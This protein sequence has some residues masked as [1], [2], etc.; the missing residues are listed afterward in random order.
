MWEVRIAAELKISS[1]SAHRSNVPWEICTCWIV[2]TTNYLTSTHGQHEAAL[3]QH[4]EHN[5]HYVQR[6]HHLHHSR[7]LV[8]QISL[9]YLPWVTQQLS[10][11]SWQTDTRKANFHTSLTVPPN[12]YP[13]I[14]PMR[15]GK[16]NMRRIAR[17]DAVDQSMTGWNRGPAAKEPNMTW[18]ETYHDILEP[19]LTSEGMENNL[20]PCGAW[21]WRSEEALGKTDP[22]REI[23]VYDQRASLSPKDSP[24]DHF[25]EWLGCGLHFLF[26]G[27]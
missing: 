5:R 1:A 11:S 7:D 12:K 10:H 22:D 17:T 20:I 16:K 14:C 4:Q 27:P 21:H 26:S 3:H 9:K 19:V 25:I 13:Y 15:F 24:I 6:S 18:Y 23:F 2:M 8:R